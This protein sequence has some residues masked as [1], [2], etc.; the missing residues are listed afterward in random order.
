MMRSTLIGAGVGLLIGLSVIQYYRIS[1]PYEVEYWK[2]VV[3]SEKKAA[4]G[5]RF[6]SDVAVKH[7]GAVHD[8]YNQHPECT[9]AVRGAKQIKL[10][11]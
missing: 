2:M 3:N 6:L 11:E 7:V 5:W 10:G 4:D 8:Y 9:T 1:D